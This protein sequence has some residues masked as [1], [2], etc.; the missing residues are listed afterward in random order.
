LLAVSALTLTHP[1]A[2]QEGYRIVVHPSLTTGR[3]SRGDVSRLFLKKTTAWPDGSR[4]QPVDLERTSRARRDFSNDVHGRPP[5]AV[6]AYWQRQ[7]FS[8][9]DVPPVVK[10]SD[11]EV[12]SFVQAQPGAIG[13]VSEEASLAGRAVKV[14]TVSE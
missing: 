2:A 9:R 3:L 10:S 14:L 7:V 13:Y 11:A 8:G 6:A 1:V 12:L 5:D 4:A